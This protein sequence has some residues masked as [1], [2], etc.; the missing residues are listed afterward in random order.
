MNDELILEVRRLRSFSDFYAGLWDL[1]GRREEVR[2]TLVDMNEE[3]TQAVPRSRLVLYLKRKDSSYEYSALHWGFTIPGLRSWP[4]GQGGRQARRIKHISTPLNDAVIHVGAGDS[5]RKV[6]F[7][8]D[9]RRL[10]ANGAYKKV[11]KAITT[12][13]QTLKSRVGKARIEEPEAPLPPGGGLTGMPHEGIE[14]A[15]W[16]W[17]L[18]RGILE[19]EIELL[20][21]SREAEVARP[22]PRLTLSFMPSADGAEVAGARWTLDGIA[23]EKLTYAQIRGLRVPEAI[24]KTLSRLE[25]S[26]R[27]ITKA[28]SRERTVLEKLLGLPEPALRL[29]QEGLLDARRREVDCFGRRIDAEG[30]TGT[31]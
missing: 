5:R 18:L 21:L 17:R 29:A 4:R 30:K 26:R 27:R 10:S 9:R 12:L 24:Q 11:T 23:I 13:R 31:G 25:R 28:L 2:K 7:D 3:F 20:R 15:T 14:C 1:Y 8:F 19:K 6:F 22:D 16:G